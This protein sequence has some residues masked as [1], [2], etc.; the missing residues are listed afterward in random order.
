MRRLLFALPIL[1]A[2]GV[3]M[4]TWRGG[5][6]RP[7]RAAAAS[8]SQPRYT[9]TDGRWLRYGL[10]GRP[11]F[12]ATAQ[13]I[14]YY[15]DESARLQTVEVHALGG[16]GSPW[17]I[18][19]PEGYAPPHSQRMQLR[20]NV[21]AV[22]TWP[23]GETVNFQ[24]AYLWVDQNRRELS[25]DAPVQMRGRNR[26]ANADGLRADWTGKLV[27]LLGQVRMQYAPPG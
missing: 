11:E 26:S 22:A 17:R 27:E 12:E 13:T 9:L 15:D 4:A 24:T 19:A 6:P 23:Q 21:T 16:A 20:G 8:E 1:I 5:A 14:D 7:P 3:L 2:V 25:T 18:N 10:D